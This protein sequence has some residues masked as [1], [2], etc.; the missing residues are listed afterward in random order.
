VERRENLQKV[1]MSRMFKCHPATEA[2]KLTGEKM[3]VRERAKQ[4]WTRAPNGKGW[5]PLR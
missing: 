1:V 3:K 5:V 4:G 2:E